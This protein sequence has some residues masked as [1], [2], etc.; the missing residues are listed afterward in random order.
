MNHRELANAYTELNDPVVQRE[1]FAQQAQVQPAPPGSA[2][3]LLSA[4]QCS[5]QAAIGL[6]CCCGAQAEQGPLTA[7]PGA[8]A[9]GLPWVSPLLALCTA[10]HRLQSVYV[11]AVGIWQNRGP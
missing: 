7:P 2:H 11:A 10:V 8:G 6:C 1:R 4:L 9:A 5:A 3:R